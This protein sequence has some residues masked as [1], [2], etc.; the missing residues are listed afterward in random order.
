MADRPTRTGDAS[1]FAVST[2]TSVVFEAG[3]FRHWIK[4]VMVETDTL[5]EMEALQVEARSGKTAVRE[6]P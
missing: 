2:R 3:K 1:L 6:K 4:G 5:A